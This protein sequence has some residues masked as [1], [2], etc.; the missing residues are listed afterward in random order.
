MCEII[1]KIFLVFVLFGSWSLAAGPSETLCP[2]TSLH[3]V[4]PEDRDPYLHHRG[5]LMSLCFVR[6][7]LCQFCLYLVSNRIWLFECYS[8]LGLTH[9]F[10]LKNRCVFSKSSQRVEGSGR[11]SLKLLF[12][13]HICKTGFVYASLLM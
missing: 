7:Q 6:S 4:S 2:I 12:P 13:I 5:N 1:I 3:G 8:G 11:K 10:S 9:N